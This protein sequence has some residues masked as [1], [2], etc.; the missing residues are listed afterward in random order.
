MEE[1]NL[2]K[3]YNILSKEFNKD[4]KEKY[5]TWELHMLIMTIGSLKELIKVIQ[6]P[7][8]LE[9]ANKIY[10]QIKEEQCAFQ[11]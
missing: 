5:G 2:K 4:L 11:K 8:D 1:E 3:A 7:K 10:K 6:D 9:R